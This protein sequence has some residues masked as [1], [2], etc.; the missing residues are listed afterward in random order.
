MQTYY[1]RDVI[2]FS[3]VLKE[4][5]ARV[6]STILIIDHE[7]ITLLIVYRPQDSRFYIA[8]HYFQNSQ[9]IWLFRIRLV[10]ANSLFK[11]HIVVSIMTTHKQNYHFS[12]ER[13]IFF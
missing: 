3:K 1:Q 5:K 9:R 7:V 6:K 4:I 8:I 2:F 11:T 13:S 12:I 10:N